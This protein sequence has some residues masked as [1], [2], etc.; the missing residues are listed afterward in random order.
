MKNISISEEEWLSIENYLEGELDAQD[1]Q[2]FEQKIAEDKVFADKVR[3]VKL[4]G[5]SIG[6][7]AMEEV[8]H[9]FST[10]L[11]D[12]HRSVPAEVKPSYRSSSNVNR[13]DA[14]SITFQNWM[15]AA[16]FVLLVATGIYW[17]FYFSPDPY[18]RYYKTE[19]GLYTYMGNTRDYNF[20]QGMVEYKTG[21]YDAAL[22][23]WRNVRAS[24]A[25][26]DTLNY[27]IG[28]AYLAQG[29][30]RDAEKYLLQVSDSQ[31]S[32]L[33]AKANWYLGLIKL[34]QKQPVDA[35]TYLMKSENSLKN[36]ILDELKN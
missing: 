36:E 12:E 28:N 25:F 24:E 22:D 9:R 29:N 16:T 31:K 19:I 10:K 14:S 15:I 32:N 13:Q 20:D 18:T 23:N 33:R 35:K 7:A 4:Y 11:R 21:N 34:K 6:D 27:Y 8:L 3:Q 30:F 17:A 5:K 2:H 1:V 26:A